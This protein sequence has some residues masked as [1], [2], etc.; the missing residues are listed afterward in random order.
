MP[1]KHAVSW[2]IMAGVLIA[3][4][5][6]RWRSSQFHTL[7]SYYSRKWVYSY[8]GSF[9]CLILLSWYQWT[10]FL[11]SSWTTPHRRILRLIMVFRIAHC[12]VFNWLKKKCNV[13]RKGC[14]GQVAERVLNF[15]NSNCWSAAFILFSLP[16]FLSTSLPNV[17]S[18]WTSK[19]SCL[20]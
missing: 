5:P 20:C 1:A 14:G 13:L 17:C 7:P 11:A 19:T 3:K 6:R 8:F 18:P 16:L 15:A 9:L 2:A 10:S 12:I 4:A